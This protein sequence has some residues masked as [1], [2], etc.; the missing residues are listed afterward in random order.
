MKTREAYGRPTIRSLPKAMKRAIAAYDRGQLRKADRLAHAILRVKG[1]Y[2]D[3]LYL[4]ALVDTRKRRFGEAVAS[5]DRALAVRPDYAEALYNRGNTLHELKRFDEALLSYDRA[6]AVRPDYAEALSNRGNT[7]HELERFDEALASYD[8]ALA[9]RLD[10]AEALYNRGNTLQELKRFDEALL[11]YDRA[12]AVRPD[13]AEALS[14]RGNALLVLKRF[15]E[16]LASYDRSIAIKSDDATGYTNRAMGRLLL[17]RYKEGW[18]DYEWRWQATDFLSK[19]PN[20]NVPIWQN[21]DLSG[22]HLLVFGEQGLGDV[23]QYARYLFF[24]AQHKCKISFL[25]SDK[26]VRLLR[27]SISEVEIVS[28]LDGVQAIDFQVPLMSLPHR[29]GTELSS[30]PNKVP[31]LRAEAELEARWRAR[32]GERGFKIGIAWQGK[33]GIRIDRGRSIPLERYFPLSRLPGVR[34][35]SLQKHFGVDQLSRLPCG[36]GIETFGDDFD[37]GRDAFVDTAA[38]MNNLD[39]IITS[40]TSIAHLAGALARPTWVALK[41]VPEWRWM[42]FREDCPWYPTLRLF[43]QLEPDDWL[44]VF[45]KIENELRTMLSPA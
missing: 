29:F 11:N 9:V 34:L 22:R 15:D 3:A 35:I 25:V 39:L 31:Y 7:L 19:R 14:S 8:R 2:F 32:I 5:Y 21:E 4:I 20:I 12:L 41:Q 38:M 28:T 36:V 1:D 42:L 30:I 18:E 45:S 33:P 16:A 17:G 23:I 13:Y 27:S 26:L 6:L 10:H 44:S 37:S 40:D 43:R 24:L